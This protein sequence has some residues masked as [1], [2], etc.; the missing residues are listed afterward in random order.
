MSWAARSVLCLST[1]SNLATRLHNIMVSR[2]GIMSWVNGQEKKE[3]YAAEGAG[4]SR[5]VVDGADGGH[6]PCN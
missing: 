5:M 6:E 4:N 3:A 2:L 1:M